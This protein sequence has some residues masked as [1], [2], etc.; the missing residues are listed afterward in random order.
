MVELKLGMVMFSPM[1]FSAPQL[2]TCGRIEKKLKW[3]ITKTETL[4][5]AVPAEPVS[6]NAGWVVG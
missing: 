6:W 4:F 3:V 2:L 5:G 1:I